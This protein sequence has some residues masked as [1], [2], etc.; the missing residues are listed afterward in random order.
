MDQ[1]R[2]HQLYRIHNID[3]AMNSLWEFYKKNF[4]LLFIPSIIMSL[5]LQYISTLVNIK[6]LQPVTDPMVILEKA[7]DFILPMII[8]SLIT[9]LF[10][11]II[12]YYIIYF[13]GYSKKNIFVPAIR[14][15]R[16]FVPYII[17]MI[18][19]A[20]AGSFAIVLDCLC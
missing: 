18:L 14:S 3:S 19:L 10:S 12:H 6:D 5:I 7:K 9:L 1:F 20:F 15:L 11:T 8:M 13:P 17:I 4:L 2:N 16:Y